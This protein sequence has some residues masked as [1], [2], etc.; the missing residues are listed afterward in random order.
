M[1]KIVSCFV[2]VSILLM[3]CIPVSAK[4][5][6]KNSEG[7][8][9]SDAYKYGL[10]QLAEKQDIKHDGQTVLALDVNKPL[11][12]SFAD[13]SSVTYILT[14]DQTP[15]P[16][17]LIEEFS[18]SYTDSI[19]PNSVQKNLS[20]TAH[21]TYQGTNHCSITLSA[22]CTF[23]NRTV[24]INYVWSSATIDKGD[25]THTASIITKRGNSLGDARASVTGV[26]KYTANDRTESYDYREDAKYDPTNSSRA[27]LIV[28]YPAT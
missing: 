13:G 7:L 2:S 16:K 6:N 17:D 25:V 15:P 19:V 23:V 26:M 18:S 9:E 10:Q 4:T 3:L 5:I 22:C 24:T 21:Y 12:K 27:Y 14:E 28:M 8:F 1:K 11:T 20:V